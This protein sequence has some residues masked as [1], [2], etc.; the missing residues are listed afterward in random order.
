MWQVKNRITVPRFP[1]ELNAKQPQFQVRLE[2]LSRSGHAPRRGTP[3]T[4][5]SV[6][7]DL[8]FDID[9]WKPKHWMST[10]YPN[11]RHSMSVIYAYIDPSNHPN[12]GKYTIHGV[13]GK[14]FLR[15]FGRPWALQ[16]NRSYHARGAVRLRRR[17]RGHHRRERIASQRFLR[18]R[19]T[20]TAP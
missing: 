14:C 8:G 15:F 19:P 2:V 18:R 13:S 9:R 3:R 6:T 4:G 11:P 17:D 5:S 1:A 16:T 10:V 20:G 12:V 7:C